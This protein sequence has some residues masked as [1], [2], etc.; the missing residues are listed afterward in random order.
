M[1]TSCLRPP[2]QIPTCVRTCK[3]QPPPD[4]LCRSA[5]HRCKACSHVPNLYSSMA[6]IRPNNHI[7]SGSGCR[8]A[9]P[10]VYIGRRRRPRT[11][12]LPLI[13]PLVRTNLILGL[14]YFGACD[15]GPVW[16][17]CTAPPRG[18]IPPE[19]ADASASLHCTQRA[20]RRPTPGEGQGVG[21][22]AA[23]PVPTHAMCIPTASDHLRL[24][25]ICNV[26]ARHVQRRRPADVP[27]ARRSFSPQRR[28]RGIRI[29]RGILPRC[30]LW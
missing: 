9:W 15:G 10:P 19:R 29:S 28:V 20:H 12:G 17:P 8:K 14:R 23:P 21:A 1:P 5:R 6:K 13:V 16:Q 18:A 30:A 25:A 26:S 11:G 3:P 27:V 22:A 2:E 4:T 24:R 7:A